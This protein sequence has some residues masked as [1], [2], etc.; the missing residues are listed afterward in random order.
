M[1][2]SLKYHSWNVKTLVCTPLKGERKFTSQKK[3]NK[4]K[5]T[6]I[7]QKIVQSSIACLIS[8]HLPSS[9]AV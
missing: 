5:N 9:G 2:K 8:S 4:Q 6:H 3:T 7:R 1:Q